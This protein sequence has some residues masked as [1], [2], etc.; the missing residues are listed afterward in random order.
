MAY[1]I[2][3]ISVCSVQRRVDKPYGLSYR[4]FTS[5]MLPTFLCSQ[6]ALA[7]S[8]GA[9]ILDGEAPSWHPFQLDAQH[10]LGLQPCGLR[11]STHQPLR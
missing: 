7:M 5:N 11:C 6:R 1:P 8:R 4:V 3:R 10:S 9:R 2:P